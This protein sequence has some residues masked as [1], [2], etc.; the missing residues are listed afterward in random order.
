MLRAQ[1]FQTTILLTGD[2]DSATEKELLDRRARSLS[3]VDVLKIAHHGS[4]T[5][6]SARWLEHIDPS[7]ALI[8]CGEG[9]RY[10]HPSTTVIDRLARRGVPTLRTD[11]SGIIVVT[12]EEGRGLRIELPG[13]PKR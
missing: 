12:M 4:K 9:N 2:I 6:T 5:S 7:L 3:S 13:S 10:G 1:V 11:R 8:S